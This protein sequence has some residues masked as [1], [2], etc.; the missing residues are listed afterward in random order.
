MATWSSLDCIDFKFNDSEL[1]HVTRGCE[2]ML[3]DTSFTDG[4]K[5]NVL[6]SKHRTFSEWGFLSFAT[7]YIASKEGCVTCSALSAFCVENKRAVFRSFGVALRT[8]VIGSTISPCSKKN[9]FIVRNV[10]KLV[11]RKTGP[12]CSLN[13]KYCSI[14]KSFKPRN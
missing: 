5:F 9:G 4:T 7:L 14:A 2:P 1:P 10:C 8:N 12:C 11:F 3:I 6:F 13:T